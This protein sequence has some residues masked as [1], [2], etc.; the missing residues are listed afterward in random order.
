M[1]SDLDENFGSARFPRV[2]VNDILKNL[3]VFCDSVK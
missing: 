3:N 2:Q 1:S